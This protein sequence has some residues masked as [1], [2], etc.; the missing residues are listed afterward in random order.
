M[1]IKVLG[2]LPNIQVRM[3]KLMKY[4][5]ALT[6]IVLS[7][8]LMISSCDINKTALGVLEGYKQA[9]NNN[10]QLDAIKYGK[11]V[12]HAPWSAMLQ[13][14]VDERG[15]VDY[16]GFE[17]DS[18]E[19]NVYLKTLSDNVPNPDA[20]SKD[21]RLAYWINAYN[22]YTVK[23]ILIKRPLQS[24]KDAGGSI[25]MVNSP[26]DEKFFYL[27]GIEFDLNTIEHEIIRPRFNDAR[28]HVAVNCA[29]ISCPALL[30]Q[31]YTEADL[32]SQ[33]D[34]QMKAFLKD[35]NK[36]N[37][38]AY[39]AEIS[40]I[41]SWFKSDFTQNGS[42]IDFLNKYSDN[43]LNTDTPLKYIKY[44]W[45]LNSPENMKEGSLN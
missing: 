2:L 14:Y 9:T 34:S 31:A 43:K 3:S 28:I 23:Y 30:D 32:Q 39:P 44:D 37:L 41:F 24:I 19:L 17:K 12:D 36:N 21:E 42:V 7:F 20:T 45:R 11:S 6:L 13:R 8:T 15:G 33:L 22:A 38:T 26:W 29:S 18:I 1:T 16:D 27:G 35:T 5:I 4:T 40:S 25:T 10:V